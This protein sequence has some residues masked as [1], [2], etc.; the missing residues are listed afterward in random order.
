MDHL[1]T[2]KLDKTALGLKIKEIRESK[3][4]TQD[5]VAAVFAWN[6]QVISDI[7]TGKAQSLEKIMLLS[8]YFEVSLDAFKKAALVC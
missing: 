7:E 8:E 6:K 5:D 2:L 3:R 4:L 1:T